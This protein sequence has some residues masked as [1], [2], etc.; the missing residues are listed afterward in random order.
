MGLSLLT[1]AVQTPPE[2]AVNTGEWGE[3]V[4]QTADAD[5]HLSPTAPYTN[6][7]QHGAQFRSEHFI[8]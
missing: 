7:A 4:T 3:E 8:F 5:T 1:S 6:T 2:C